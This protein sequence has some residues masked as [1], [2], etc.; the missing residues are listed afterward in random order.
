MSLTL[1]SSTSIA[2]SGAA[3]SGVELHQV[4]FG[5]DPKGLGGFEIATAVSTHAPSVG[6]LKQLHKSR[7]SGRDTS[8]VVAVVHGDTVWMFGPDTALQ[9]L[10]Q[11]K[12]GATRHLQAALDEGDSLQATKR[13][14]SLSDAQNQTQMPGVRNKGLFATYHLR[15]NTKRRAD[16]PQYQSNSARIIH[17]RSRQLIEEL[18][19]VVSETANHTL[20]L[21]DSADT[22]RAV[23]LLLD[24]SESF[25]NESPR[26]H[27]SP[28]AWGLSIAAE[29][30]V[31]WLIMLRKEQI[32]LYPA[33][34][35][36][37]V[38]QKGQT[39]TYLEL[40]LAG[41]GEDYMGLLTLVFSAE[42]LG[43][44][45]SAQEL[46]DESVRYATA[47]G[48]RLRERIY[49]RV[50]PNLAKAVAL[51]MRTL[52]TELDVMGLQDAYRTTLR[53]LFRFLFQAY[54][55]DRGLL[56]AGRNNLFDEHSLTL[57]AS[58]AVE[59]DEE[60][61][62]GT[63]LWEMLQQVWEAIDVGNEEWRVPAY[64]GGL[65]GSDPELR[66]YGA[67]IKRLALPDSVIGPA[68]EALLIDQTE[69][70]VTGMVDF[71]S[72]SVREFG[73][74][75]EGLLESSLSLADSDLALDAN[76]TWLPAGPGD[77]VEARAGEPYFHNTS[78]ERKATGSYFTPDFI[79]DHLIERSIDPSLDDHLSRIKALIDD[80]KDN[81]AAKK[82]FD[83][84]VADLAMGSA[85]FLVAAVDRIES[86]MR[87]FLAQPG[88]EIAGV[89]N[90]LERLAE[91]AR[92]ALGD[93]LVAI[94][95]I[96]DSVLL[97]RQ[98]AR[99]C[100]YGID[101]NPLAV[102]LS[103]LALWIHTFVPGLPMS[104]L[105]HNLVCGDSLTGI[106]SIDEGLNALIPGRES[107]GVSLFDSVIEESLT[108]AK[109]LLQDMANAD[110][111]DKGQM[112]EAA[113]I[114]RKAREA[115]KKAKLIF[116]V[117][118][119]NRVGVI[120]SGAALTEEVLISL[121][122]ESAVVELLK[123]I[124]PAH[125][126]FL[127]PEVFVRENPG[128]D[129]LVGNP[130][131]KEANIAELDF[132]NQRFGSL[133]GLANS[134][135]ISQI[136]SF[137]EKHPELEKEF[138]GLQ[139]EMSVLR[140]ALHAGPYP[141]MAVG[142]PDLYKAFA[143][144]YL[145]LCR[146]GG[147]ISLVMPHSIWSTKG[148]SNWRA[149]FFSRT[150]SEIVQIINSEGWAFESVNPGYRFSFISARLSANSPS[151]VVRGTYR[152]R[153]E[154]RS[155][156]KE[157]VPRIQSE[158]IAQSDQHC[159]LP[160][161]NGADEVALWSKVLSF[162][163]LGDG[164]REDS[165][166]DI[167]CAPFR[168]I[169]VTEDGRKKGVFTSSVSDHPVF[170]HLN[171]LQYRFDE[172][173][174][175]FNYADFNQYLKSQE[176]LANT[177]VNRRDS[178]LSLWGRSRLEEIGHPISSPRLV[179]RAIIHSSNQRKVWVALAPANTLLTNASPYLVFPEDDFMKQAYL[180]G[181]L[182]S[183]VV[184]WFGALRINLN[185]NF[186]ILYSLPVPVF[187]GS[188]RQKRIAELAARLAVSN[189]ADFG[190]WMDFGGPIESERERES[191]MIEVDYLV[192]EEFQLSESEIQVVFGSGNKLRPSTDQLK[193]L[194][195][196]LREGK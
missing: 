35:G 51:E 173:L 2:W 183:G 91:A 67:L 193:K 108:E 62:Q 170:N 166:S 12:D 94:D 49:D 30:G 13:F 87:S 150:A 130:P 142:D 77:T 54:A 47:L 127:F 41:L 50:V 3:P 131:F 135:Q 27:S 7:L 33:R 180:L 189:D 137:K 9:P 52:G 10:K 113:G 19:F 92:K 1:R 118:V 192:C 112:K 176:I 96:D 102:E 194:E 15:E 104:T 178:A 39:E 164:R 82:F 28:V 161:L 90:E 169:D 32:R 98:I 85:H 158:L 56:P 168:E 184:D 154:F 66:P 34:D 88:N 37:G 8:L 59:R 153:E 182:N 120:S 55:E 95:D 68:L 148:S 122:S 14:L 60:Y 143:W 53:I 188:F 156:L 80:G 177:L 81:E 4:H 61:R 45:G 63:G 99:R 89:S 115:A 136:A 110:E 72:L 73:T 159:T 147:S 71:R 163:P 191:A 69:D 100:I 116:D 101:V 132:W 46:L 190:R 162:P 107:H 119:A 138:S 57:F 42:A 38:G 105:D 187:T 97:R 79:V 149:E 133:K 125:M 165:R 78:G 18:G 121:H 117:A 175:P 126:P 64:N 123:A 74:I 11:P 152:S 17:S 139:Q 146:Q 129:V 128:F 144:R 21:N 134:D 181:V 31:P 6:D 171:V 29:R 195:A 185:L 109:A 160:S 23:A 124:N 155:G 83:Y 48:T 70:Q 44:K 36:V 172:Q 157:E 24:E 151:A 65:F 179:Y 145:G 196:D 5:P 22:T 86:K 58:Q 167:R 140:K 75:Y 20:V 16:W 141:G 26:F 84:R 174:G 114:A 76:G 111:A 43:E 106:G 25:E 103:R 186:F 40:D 93:D